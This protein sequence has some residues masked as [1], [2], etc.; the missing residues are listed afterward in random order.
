MFPFSL[1]LNNWFI[2]CFDFSVPSFTF[3]PTGIYLHLPSFFPLFFW[4]VLYYC[5]SVFISFSA[6]I[7]GQGLKMEYNTSPTHVRHAFEVER[8]GVTFH[9][10]NAVIY[11]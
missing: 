5:V 6:V 4:H 11:S 10:L 7:W 8:A 2:F 9:P 3:T 1:Q